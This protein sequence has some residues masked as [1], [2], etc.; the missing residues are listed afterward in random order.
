M[1]DLS[2]DG[3]PDACRS[4]AVGVRELAGS[5]GSAGDM[6]AEAMIRAAGAWTGDSSD[7]FTSVTKEHIRRADTVHAE[8]LLF[9]AGLDGFAAGLHSVQT[10]MTRARAIATRAGIRVAVA[11]PEAGEIVLEPGQEGPLDHAVGVASR[12]REH[13]LRLQNSLHQL[14]TRM[15]AVVWEPREPIAGTG[16]STPGRV[17]SPLSGLPRRLGNLLPDLDDLPLPAGPLLNP[18][19]GVLSGGFDPPDAHELRKVLAE[20]FPGGPRVAGL[21]LIALMNPHLV[22]QLILLKQVKRIP[23]ASEKIN[24]ALT[25]YGTLI[26]RTGRVYCKADLLEHVP[27]VGEVVKKLDTPATP[28]A[29]EAID[30]DIATWYADLIVESTNAN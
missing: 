7:A 3:S 25:G 8:L 17:L 1:I 6:L 24:R 23:G 9:A 28:F 19:K 12:S 16:S 2:V 29:C 27:K 22:G 18:V 30:H 11:L 13:E 21:P 4:C 15:D 14:I 5:V 10:E 26:S 20:I